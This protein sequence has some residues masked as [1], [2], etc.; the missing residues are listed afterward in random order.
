[1]RRVSILIAALLLLALVFG[2]AAEAG[3]KR[4]KRVRPQLSGAVRTSTKALA[5]GVHRKPSG[6]LRI[7]ARAGAAAFTTLPITVGANQNVI[8]NDVTNSPG[9]PGDHPLGPA[10]FV[11]DQTPQNETTISMNP[12]DSMD[13]VGGAND[14]RYFLPSEGRFDGAGGAYVS[15]D[16]GTTWTNT[17]IP[18]VSEAAGGTYQGVGDPAFAWDPRSG[19]STVYYANIAFNRVAN[20][21]TG[22]SAFA[23]S[24]VV[25]KSTNGGDTWG[26][27]SFVVQDDDPSVFHDKEWIGV[28]PDGA[29]YVTWAR[30]TFQ[31]KGKTGLGNYEASPIVISKSTDGGAT[32]ST[33]TVISGPFAQFSTP[34]IH[35]DGTPDGVIY[36]S[37]EEWNNPVGRNGGR[38]FVARSTDG[39]ATWTKHFVGLVNDLPS[40]LPHSAFRDASYP[41]L[42]VA[43]DGTLHMVWSNWQAGSADI[44]YTRSADGGDSWSRPVKINQESVKTDQFFQWID[45]SGDYV[46]VGFVDRQYTDDALL[47]HSYVVSPDGGNTWS[48]TVRVTTASSSPD[49]SLF[50]ANCTG[51]FIGDYTGIVGDGAIAHVLWMDGR[52]GTQPGGDG[53]DQD[54]FYAKV[55][56]GA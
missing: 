49:A 20:P 10:C 23:S 40:P 11:G 7:A 8:V 12:N 27:P 53:T 9:A 43:E 17:F 29:V 51:E 22:H 24:V 46:H 13:L 1:M 21:A 26:P 55:T 19:L 16:G 6:S 44:V 38:A 28:G 5:P 50:G 31:P 52:P 30:F 35:D 48:Q 33:P 3:K 32:W 56:V 36:V 54:A 14:Y 15:H 2:S 41:V 47:D 4:V 39:G 45:A 25:N 42:D 34:V 18:G 37:F